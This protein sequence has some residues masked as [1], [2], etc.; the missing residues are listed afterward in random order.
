MGWGQR[1]TPTG[2]HRSGLAEEKILAERYRAEICLLMGFLKS[3]KGEE[4]FG[5]SWR[6]GWIFTLLD[7]SQMLLGSSYSF[8]V[9]ETL[10]VWTQINV[11]AGMMPY[12][13]CEYRCQSRQ[14]QGL[15]PEKAHVPEPDT[16]VGTWLCSPPAVG[17]QPASTNAKSRGK[18]LWEAGYLHGF[19]VVSTDCLL[20][21]LQGK[22]LLV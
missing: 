17:L 4:L 11:W 1:R 7:S 10:Q 22:K 16:C 2:D 9:H 18:S 20:D 5:A 21:E 19:K 3:P 15:H 8:Q 14:M 12:D 13:C 6:G